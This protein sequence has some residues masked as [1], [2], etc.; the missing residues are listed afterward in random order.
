MDL[1]L[2]THTDPEKKIIHPWCVPPSGPSG[3]EPPCLSWWLLRKKNVNP[4]SILNRSKKVIIIWM[5]VIITGYSF[6]WKHRSTSI[7]DKH[8]FRTCFLKLDNN[9]N[10]IAWGLGRRKTTRN[11]FDQGAV[12]QVVGGTCSPWEWTMSSSHITTPLTY[13]VFFFFFSLLSFDG[14]EKGGA[15]AYVFWGVCLCTCHDEEHH[16]K[17]APTKKKKN[18]MSFLF[19]SSL[20]FRNH[21]S[22][23]ETNPVSSLVFDDPFATHHFLEYCV[24][25]TSFSDIDTAE[26]RMR[27]KEDPPLL[28]LI[29]SPNS[30]RLE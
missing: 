28:L 14:G 25:Y 24:Y 8:M 4:P 3:I 22:G 26:Y 9:R 23:T 11:G 10:G 5:C 17:V 27:L 13:P 2:N 30:H 6:V 18:G 12:A 1:Y 15:A 19:F 16:E 21:L 29:P 20:P 7:T